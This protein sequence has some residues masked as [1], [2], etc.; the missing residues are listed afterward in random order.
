MTEEYTLNPEQKVAAP[1][2]IPREFVLDLFHDSSWGYIEDLPEELILWDIENDEQPD[3]RDCAEICFLRWP[4]WEYLCTE[5]ARVVVWLEQPH[6]GEAGTMWKA[7]PVRLLEPGCPPE[8][9]E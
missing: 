9:E 4:Q 7:T 5:G 6:S 3:F 1:H 8:D 2:Y